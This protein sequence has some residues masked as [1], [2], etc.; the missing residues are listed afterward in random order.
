M[1]EKDI[2]LW[3]KYFRNIIKKSNIARNPPR[4]ITILPMAGRGS[5][6]TD[7]KY[8]VPKPLIN[9]NEK[10]MVVQAVECIPQSDINVFACLRQHVESFNVEDV[11]KDHFSNSKIQIIDQVTEGQACTCDLIISGQEIC[12]E[13]PIQI[14]ACDNGVAYDVE[15]YQATVDDETNDVIV[16]TFRG[17]STSIENP[18]AYAWLEVDGD[19][20]VKHVSCKK[21][22]YDDPTVTHA[23]IGTMFFRKTRYFTEGLHENIRMNH[24]TNG[25]F[26]VDDVLNRCIDR[27]LKVKVF[28]VDNYICWGTPDDYETYLKFQ[29]HFHDMP[30]HP[31]RIEL[32]T[33]RPDTRKN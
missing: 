17:H 18:N 4:T 25:E 30:N 32:D 2:D 14:S 7:K 28:E 11:L 12:P 6:F 1:K 26:Y 24:R 13:I 16:W 9:V 5:R 20:F 22:I 23:I 10:P 33:T 8:T 27:G 3:D 29:K 31:Y 21:F 15:K 19:G